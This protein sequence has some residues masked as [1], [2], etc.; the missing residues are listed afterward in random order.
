MT[1]KDARL[2]KSMRK[3]V[4]IE[5]RN[6]IAK[7]TERK[8]SRKTK[9][10]GLVIAAHAMGLYEGMLSVLLYGRKLRGQFKEA[11]NHFN[12]DGRHE[13]VRT[14]AEDACTIISEYLSSVDPEHE[15][16]LQIVRRP[17]GVK[18]A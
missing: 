2:I 10:I 17:K 9:D 15:C 5:V 13:I 4:L 12:L 8:C 14:M 6:M 16:Q 3:I 18:E 11:R 7:T 1:A